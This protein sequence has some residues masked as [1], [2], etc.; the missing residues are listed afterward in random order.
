MNE[1][2]VN[3]SHKIIDATI[4]VISNPQGQVVDG[5]LQGMFKICSER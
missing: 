3:L 4:I 2:V 1:E 5:F